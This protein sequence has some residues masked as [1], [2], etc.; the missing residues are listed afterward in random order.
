M[1]LEIINIALILLAGYA[2]YRI[3]RIHQ[4]I[5]TRRDNLKVLIEV[6]QRF[7]DKITEGENN[8]K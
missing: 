7:N 3:G 6:M 1:I 2:A 5:I 4:Q 8:A